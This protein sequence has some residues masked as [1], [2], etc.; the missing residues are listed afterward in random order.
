MTNFN[1]SKEY[2]QLLLFKISPDGL[3]TFI[4]E[5][6]KVG[7]IETKTNELLI[8]FHSNCSTEC[9]RFRGIITV[10]KD[11]NEATSPVLTTIQN[12]TSV[13]TTTQE[14]ITTALPETTSNKMTTSAS[15]QTTRTIS[16]R[17]YKIK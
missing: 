9:S 8:L 17:K 5:V 4:T 11:Y 12:P 16:G 6:T 7:T 14:V 10:V 3:V 2:N 15:L 13:L 1:K